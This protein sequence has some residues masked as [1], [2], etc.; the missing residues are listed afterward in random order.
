VANISLQATGST[1]TALLPLAN[2]SISGTGATR[3]VNFTPVTGQFG[4]STVTLTVTD[5]D[6]STAT[7]TFTVTFNDTVNPTAI[8]Q[9]VTV[10]L[11]TNGQGSTT[12]AAI[13]NGSSD[14]CGITTITASPLTFNGTN[15]GANTVTLTVTDAKGNVG[16]ATS[17]VTVIDNIAPTVITQNTTVSIAANGQVVL[18]PAQVNNGSFDNVGITS[19]TV[20]PSTFNCSNLGPNTV[21][22]TATDASGNTSS[23]THYKSNYYYPKYHRTSKCG[24]YLQFSSVRS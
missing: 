20:N 11:G 2:I 5:G 8:A 23:S 3:T 7:R 15:L 19:L 13:N 16:T 9:N 21:T 6:G 22:L 18:T 10:Y 14:N 4:T 1:N 24:R 17:T 12:T